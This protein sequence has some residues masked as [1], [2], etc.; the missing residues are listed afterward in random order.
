[1]LSDGGESAL[2]QR[3]VFTLMAETELKY[4]THD[5]SLLMGFW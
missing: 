3:N 5:L 4:E 1:M 2:G